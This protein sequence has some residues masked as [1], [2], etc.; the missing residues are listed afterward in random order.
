MDDAHSSPNDELTGASPGT[1]VQDPPA[2]TPLVALIGP[3]N[4]GKTTLFNRLT[5]LRQKVANYPGVT[6]EKHVGRACLPDEREVD[7]VD[8]PGVHGFS[9]RTLDEKI[10]RDVLEGR[11]EGLRSPD[12][13]VLIVDCTRLE[14]QLML[15][16]P[17]SEGSAPTSISASTHWRVSLPPRPWWLA[18]G[19]HRMLRCSESSREET[20]DGSPSLNSPFGSSMVH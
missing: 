18:P 13:L 1:A 6:V 19:S 14:S 17:T 16:E 12:A 20:Y 11:M 9:A 7:I 2:L 10:T 15:V 4:S 3:P 5:G 8:L